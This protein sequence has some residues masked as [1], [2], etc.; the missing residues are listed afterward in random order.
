MSRIVTASLALLV[1]VW[2][3]APDASAQIYRYKDA[4]GRVH[5]VSS[6][7]MVPPE[8]REAA[9]ADTESRRGGGSVNVVE[10]PKPEAPAATTPAA[11]APSAPPM[12]EDWWRS[13]AIQ[14]QRAVEDARAD[15][16]AAQKA[17]EDWTG[18]SLSPTRTAQRRPMRKDRRR[19]SDDVY[20]DATDEPTVEE[21]QTELQRAER[22]LTDFEERARRA[23]VPPGWLR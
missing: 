4:E 23:G 18:K 9:R 13:Q 8:Y 15:L 19:R 10:V 12:N 20:I 21:L 7:N 16:E 2:L 22:D 14:K 3:I 5:A 11:S 1:S 6:L 17:E